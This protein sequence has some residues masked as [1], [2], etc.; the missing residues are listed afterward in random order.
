MA[1]YNRRVRRAIVEIL[2][3]EGPLTKD[4]VH[5]RLENHQSINS[6]PSP[7]S[8]GALLS[9]NPQVIKVG[10]ITMENLSG[11]RKRETQFDVNRVLIQ[12]KSDIL[13]TLP[14]NALLKYET[15]LASKCPS[16]GRSRIFRENETQ[17]L[18]CLRQG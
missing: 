17:C 8:L 10:S 18:H 1:G 9:K 5:T 11:K 15:P 12:E 4:E 14:L 6:V 7:N 3:F 13:H 2:W 16:C